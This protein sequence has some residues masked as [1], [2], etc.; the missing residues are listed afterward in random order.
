MVA[1]TEGG[2]DL[3]ALADC[4]RAVGHA[5]LAGDSARTIPPPDGDTARAAAACAAVVPGLR[6]YWPL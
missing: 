2:Y 6:A 5:M 4:T 3:K 1:L